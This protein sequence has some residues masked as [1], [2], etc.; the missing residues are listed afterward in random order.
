M[1]KILVVDDDIQ[2][3]E[4]LKEI[5]TSN[6]HNVTYLSDS[7]EALED[8]TRYD[9][10]LLDLVMPKV[11]GLYLLSKFKNS[12][13]D[14]QVIMITAF[15]TIES[16]VGAMRSGATDYISKPFRSKQIE[17]AIQR[18]LEEVKFTSKI[19]EKKKVLAPP[20]D[21]EVQEVLNTLA[22]PIRHGIVE[23][24]KERGKSTFGEVRSYLDI[25]DSPKLSFTP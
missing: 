5:L 23:M 4:Q 8:E 9:I 24:L 12:H 2:I 21:E 1:A 16:A 17:T 19:N 11:D 20:Y 25:E 7:E 10:I 14:T 3:G 13:P 22:N 6:G 15:A 18:A